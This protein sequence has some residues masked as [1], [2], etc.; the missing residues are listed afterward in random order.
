MCSWS[1]NG[2]LSNEGNSKLKTK[3]KLYVKKY[4]NQYPIVEVWRFLESYLRR[5]LSFNELKAFFIFSWMH[6]NEFGAPLFE[7]LWMPCAR[8]IPKPGSN[9]PASPRDLF[10]FS[11]FYSQSSRMLLSAGAWPFAAISFKF[12]LRLLSTRLF[13]SALSF[14]WINP[15]V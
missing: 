8:D 12:V 4:L 3:S 1:L 13:I 7:V 9:W 10:L 6:A 2:I 14:I 11:Y 15:L 5:H